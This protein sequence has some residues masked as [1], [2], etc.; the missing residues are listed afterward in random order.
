MMDDIEK[1]EEEAAKKKKGGKEEAGAMG[2]TEVVVS[3]G[4]YE[5]MGLL[6]ASSSL[7]AEVLQNWRHLQGQGLMQRLMEF[8]KGHARASAHAEVEIKK[9]RDYGLVHNLLQHIKN[10]PRTLAHR[11]KIDHHNTPGPQ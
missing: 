8:A 2:R 3:Q 11:H 7:I 6:G 10:L 4:F 9:G 1:T 5:K